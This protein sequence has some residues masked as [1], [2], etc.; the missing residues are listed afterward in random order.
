MDPLSVIGGQ[1]LQQ[2]LL[3]SWI[4]PNRMTEMAGPGFAPMP[5]NRKDE[6][7]LAVIMVGIVVVMALVMSGAL[8]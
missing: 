1:T 5:P 6:I 3:T 4:P 8:K 7:L 2:P